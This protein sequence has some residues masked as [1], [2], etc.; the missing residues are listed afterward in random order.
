MTEKDDANAIAGR[1]RLLGYIAEQVVTSKTNEEFVP[2]LLGLGLL[3]KQTLRLATN[4]DGEM[5]V[6]EEI[7][8]CAKLKKDGRITIQE[9]SVL[10][11]IS[12]VNH[13]LNKNDLNAPMIFEE[14]DEDEF[15][16]WVEEGK[17]SIEE[18]VASIK[19]INFSELETWEEI[20]Q[21]YTA[22]I[23]SICRKLICD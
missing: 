7:E 11:S 15:G 3:V 12:T 9:A 19:M 16:N 23:L 13:Y 4:F 2:C 21:Q 20:V 5:T 8:A 18:P 10:L 1:D 22:K 6:N 17:S 14:M